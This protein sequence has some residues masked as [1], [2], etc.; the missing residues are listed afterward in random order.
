MNL[1][2]KYKSNNELDIEKIILDYSNYIIRIIKNNSNVLT[3]EDMEE[4]VID[5]FLAIWNNKENQKK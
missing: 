2:E 5:V 4:I 3:N 1:I